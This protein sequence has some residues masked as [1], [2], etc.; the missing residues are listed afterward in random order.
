[1]IRVLLD[2]GLAPRAA[3]L[4][5]SAGWDAVHVSEAGLERA[6]DSEILDF[7]QRAGRTCI[8]LDHDFHLHLAL[9][10]A[11]KPSVILL[12]VQGLAA[13]RQAQLVRAVYEVC[14]DAVAEGA[15][16]S[17]DESSIRIRRLPLREPLDGGESAR[18]QGHKVPR[19]YDRKQD[20]DAGQ[21]SFAS[22]APAV[23]AQRQRE[24]LYEQEAAPG[25]RGVAQRETHQGIGFLDAVQQEGHSG[26]EIQHLQVRILE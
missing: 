15:A 10:R 3:V 6:E 13:E 21:E 16:V 11:G 24:H 17:A 1:V 7:A 22:A 5:R 12:R 20:I 18:D 2:Q 19:H 9:S 8:T 26:Q 25:M 23:E 4:L 14:A